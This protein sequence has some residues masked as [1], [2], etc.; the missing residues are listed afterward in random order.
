MIICVPLLLDNPGGF[1]GFQSL[2]L[3]LTPLSLC[4]FLVIAL[5][6]G[7]LSDIP[8]TL[9]IAVAIFLSS[10]TLSL[11]LSR[12][13]LVSLFGSAGRSTGLVALVLVVCVGWAGYILGR[14][15]DG[16]MST[17]RSL[18]VVGAVMSLGSLLQTVG[19]LL[20]GYRKLG[21]SGRLLGPMDSASQLG[22]VMLLFAACAVSTTLD[23][24]ETQ[25]WRRAGAVAST[26]SGIVVVLSGSRAAW[27]GLGIATVFFVVHPNVRKVVVQQRG[28]MV[29]MAAGVAI[30]LV[31]AVPSTRDRAISLFDPSGGT[32]GGRADIWRAAIPA[33]WERPLQGF[34]LDQT[35]G[36]M[37][38]H[39]ATTFETSYGTGETVD[40]A[41]SV[42][43]DQLLWGGAFGLV[44]LLGLFTAWWR[45][46]RVRS[47]E[48][49]SAAL[50]AGV[51]GFGTHLLF[52]FPVPEVDRLAWLMAGLVAGSVATQSVT[53][54]WRSS[55]YFAGAVIA[56][57]APVVVVGAMNTTADQRL[58]RAVKLEAAQNLNDALVNYKSAR[59]IA[60]FL[61]LYRETYARVLARTAAGPEI[62]DATDRA[63]RSN[64]GDP[65]LVELELR[66][67]AQVAFAAGDKDTGKNLVPE[68]EQLCNE[69]PSRI[70]FQVGL[71]LAQLTAGDIDA[72][73][74]TATVASTRAPKDP[75]PEIVLSLIEKTAG[76]TAQADAHSQE[77]TRREGR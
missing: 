38:R 8:R 55:K 34:G 60:G 63:R 35:R 65:V 26:L 64:P 67:R 1:L 71:A 54:T 16:F 11:L 48:P 19:V 56:V 68:Y 17:R 27:I 23:D 15:Y 4:A 43:L 2:F 21:P 20:P 61:P 13:P 69:Y 41:H 51:L 59:A 50:V 75:S 24:R 53:A 31:L 77:A 25:W 12:A 32:V 72:A 6:K 29:A 70:P 18:V 3:L 22:A 28:A 7:L 14:H 58:G 66:A 39:L 74:Q 46:L 42:V 76:N 49:Q 5:Q 36:P 57:L 9:A 37:M 52:N 73:R 10:T 47:L 62:I 33:W 45:S 40:R 30:A 44:A